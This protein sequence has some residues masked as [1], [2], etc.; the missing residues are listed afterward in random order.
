MSTDPNEHRRFQ[1]WLREEYPELSRDFEGRDYADRRVRELWRDWITKV[2]L[3][4]I[5]HKLDELVLGLRDAMAMLR[6]DPGN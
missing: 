5:E 3:N 6:D 4:R 1:A 2:Q